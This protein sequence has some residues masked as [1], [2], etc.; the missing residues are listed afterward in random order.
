[1]HKEEIL[2]SFSELSGAIKSINSNL[3]LGTTELDKAFS[4][5]INLFHDLNTEID[6]KISERESLNVSLQELIK[7]IES[8]KT[9][10][11][12]LIKNGNEE[13]N[14]QRND[15][16]K[17]KALE[18]KRAFE[19]NEKAKEKFSQAELLLSQVKQRENKLLEDSHKF[20]LA[21]EKFIKDRDNLIIKETILSKREESVFLKEN[22]SAIKHEELAKE[23]KE[24]KSFVEYIKNKEKIVLQI[25]EEI[26]I[27]AKVNQSNF[28]SNER[29]KINIGEIRKSLILQE[30]KLIK[31]EKE[32]EKEINR[33]KDKEK[34][35]D[36]Y[37]EEVEYKIALERQ[38]LDK[39][40]RAL[41]MRK[42]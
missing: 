32:L 23:A 10:L 29:N 4:V 38:D 41:V 35:I 30:E 36:A 11:S 8:N 6:L 22:E 28:E 37:K 27:A 13:I 33:L 26:R 2:K 7:V 31:K 3:R 24:S 34:N 16:E 19:L 12:E 9:R 17:I 40:K 20:N 25:Q 21:E 15:F 14:K 18:E 42:K 5:F 39:Q 1:M